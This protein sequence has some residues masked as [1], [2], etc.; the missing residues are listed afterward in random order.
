MRG[1]AIKEVG[2]QLFM[3]TKQDAT[4]DAVMSKF[5]TTS[6]PEGEPDEIKP[7]PKNGCGITVTKIDFP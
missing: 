3:M 2:L 4:G 5:W 6:K 7:L 1:G